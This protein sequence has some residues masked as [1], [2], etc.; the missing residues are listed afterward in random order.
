MEAIKT[1]LV[2]IGFSG[3]TFHLPFI[4]KLSEF[5][6][7]SVYTSNAEKAKQYTPGTEAYKDYGEFLASDAELVIITSPNEFH[8][9]LAKQALDCGKHVVLEKPFVITAAKGEELVQLAE[10]QQRV[11]SAYHNRRWDGDF[12]TVKQLI[13]NKTLGNLY[14]FESHFDRFRPDVPKRW[15][16]QPGPGTGLLYDLG[17]HLID[18]A[19]QLFGHPNSINAQVRIQRKRA[20]VDDYFHLVLDYEPLQVI[21][22]ASTLT[23]KPGARFTLHGDKGSWLKEGLDPQED[24]LKAGGVPGSQDWGFDKNNLTAKHFTADSCT[25]YPIEAGCYQSY[26]Q[27]IA[28][29]IRNGTRNPVTDQ[30]ATAV[31]RL[32]E[33]AAQSSRDK[34]TI[35]MTEKI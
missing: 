11:L 23:A 26:Y 21:L 5:T 27:Q 30:Q 2:G 12:L 7:T 4:N 20:Q 32:I 6:L 35:E 25:P 33:L 22:H 17:S 29:A 19:L 34:R 9:S 24:A 31:I 15:R 28:T 1:G 16:E 10:Q 14:H 3:I 8:Y 13:E 18:Q